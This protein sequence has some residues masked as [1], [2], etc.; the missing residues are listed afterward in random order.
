LITVNNSATS[1]MDSEI[2]QDSFEGAN[3][4][5]N[6]VE[7]GEITSEDIAILSPDKV[8]DLPKLTGT[9]LHT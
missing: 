5:T 7:D 4:N 1:K 6:I 8:L 3:G 9:L 2:K